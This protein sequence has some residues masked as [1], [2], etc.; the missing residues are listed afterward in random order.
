MHYQ[1]S[2]GL[3]VTDRLC[4]TS[5]SCKLYTVLGYCILWTCLFVSHVWVHVM[6]AWASGRPVRDHQ[7]R[8]PLSTVGMQL[9]THFNLICPLSLYIVYMWYVLCIDSFA[10]CLS[11]ASFPLLLPFSIFPLLS[12]SLSPC[13][14]LP[15]LLPSPSLPFPSHTHT[16]ARTHTHREAYAMNVTGLVHTIRVAKKMTHLAVSSGAGAEVWPQWPVV[17]CY[18]PYLVISTHPNEVVVSGF[19]KFGLS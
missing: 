10:H 5:T 6:A 4:D 18:A 1:C 8:I 3:T 14:P 2:I 7:G 16:H 17:V 11:P 13:P 15:S 9:W 19:M 12:L